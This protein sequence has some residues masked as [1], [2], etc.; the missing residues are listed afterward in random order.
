MEAVARLGAVAD[1]PHVGDGRLHALVDGHRS[2]H[3]DGDIPFQRQRAVGALDT[4]VVVRDVKSRD[5]RR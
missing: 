5:A 1:R 2:P 4:G 3:A